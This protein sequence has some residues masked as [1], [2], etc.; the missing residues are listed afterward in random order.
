MST[1]I[2]NIIQN[3]DTYLGDSST[4]RISEAERFQAITESTSWMLEE[5]GNEHS[6]STYVLNYLDSVNYYKVTTGLADLMIGA[7]LRREQDKQTLSF[8]RKSSR[9]IAE[10]IGQG[11]VDPSW[12]IER[13]D[14]D[15]YLVVNAPTENAVAY[16]TQFD[17]ITDGGTWTADTTGSDMLNVTQDRNERKTGAAS[18]NF[19]VDVS[20]S[21]NNYAT[22]YAPDA[23]VRDLSSKE[24][25]GSFLMHVYI[26]D[27][28]E[29]TSYTLYWGSDTGAT[30]STK[31]N[32]WAATVTSDMD[33]NTFADGWN[34]IKIDWQNATITGSPD[35]SIVGYYEIRMSYGV[36]Q[37]DDTDFRLDALRIAQPERL[38]MHYVS[39]NVGTDSTGADIT[40]FSATTD[41]PFFSGQYDQYKYAIAHKAAA[42]LYYSALRLVEQGAVEEGVAVK[43]LR[44]YRKRFESS[45]VKEVRSFKIAGVNLRRSRTRHRR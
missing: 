6:V 29:V 18:L 20:Q 39:W 19:D 44:R 28:T 37:V 8:A 2:Q 13:R 15:A 35:S 30:P 33:G 16:I 42:I 34:Q 7:D 40:A 38:T 22:L 26:P 24:D 31:A 36:G 43:A 9:E 14:G 11:I 32:Y 3:L 17:S 27:A 12:A 25:L 45:A 1:T 41:I 5:L 10:E 21:V 23:S 4:D